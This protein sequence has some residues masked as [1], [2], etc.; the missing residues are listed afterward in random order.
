[1]NILAPVSEVEKVP[2]PSLNLGS[3]LGQGF[4]EST[5]SDTILE[6]LCCIKMC[7]VM[8]S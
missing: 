1:M 5:A 8:M 4:A 2:D 6:H 7:D 3:C